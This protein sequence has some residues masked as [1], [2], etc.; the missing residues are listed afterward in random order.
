MV[1]NKGSKLSIIK[2]MFDSPLAADGIRNVSVTWKQFFECLQ[3]AGRIVPIRGDG[4]PD[5]ED[6]KVSNDKPEY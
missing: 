2:E 6:K 1:L 3:R 5:T 4:S